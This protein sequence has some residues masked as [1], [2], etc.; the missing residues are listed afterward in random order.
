MRDEGKSG[1]E[2]IPTKPNFASRLN[3]PRVSSPLMGFFDRF[4][5]KKPQPSSAPAPAPQSPPAQT[6]ASESAAT[7]SPAAP[8]PTKPRLAAARERL[9]ARDLPGAMAIYEEVLA[10]P[11]GD[12]A[13]VLVTISGDL[14]SHGHVAEIIELIAPRYDADRHGP[15][16][17]LN[18]IQAYLAVRNADAAQH[19]LDILFALNRPELEDRL[20]GFSNAIAEL[21]TTGMPS[22]MPPGLS[23]GTDPATGA[24]KIGLITLSKPVWFYGLEALGPQILP[25]KEGRLRRIAFAQLALP[26][27]SDKAAAYA[28]KQP[29]DELPRLARAI[30][31]WFAETFYFSPSYTPYA[32]VGLFTS[33]EG[34][35]QHVI[36]G[37]EWTTENLRQL[38]ET[39]E[40]GLDYIVTGALRATA[41]DYELLLRIWEVKNYRERKTFSARWTPATADAAL[42][43]IHQQLRTYM[44]W[45]PA[46]AAFAYT[47]APQP[48]P[49][50]DTLAGS[51]GLFLAEKKVLAPADTLG[52]APADLVAMAQRAPSSEAASFAFLTARARAAT[53]GV[54]APGSPSLA[55][56]PLV[57]QASA[58]SPA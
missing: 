29:D 10:G 26:T 18:L 39:T 14:G 2:K 42:A 54:P 12:R 35:N 3:S 57:N 23:A 37:P 19:V 32:A 33:P 5:S 11:T 36:F 41:G 56:S 28:A 8:T 17:G 51:L 31:L 38:V 45:S 48:R 16:T 40:G 34:T 50:L 46:S 21:L 20:H 30:P 49:W 52:A 58:L 9:D 25:P 55:R 53:L 6:A 1:R 27:Y 44:E 4:S 22:A 24:P 13:D 7:P 47:I 43:Q 15:A